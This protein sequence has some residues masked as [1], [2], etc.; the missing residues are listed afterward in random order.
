MWS[1]LQAHPEVRWLTW[2]DHAKE[3]DWRIQSSPELLQVFRDG[4]QGFR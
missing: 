1:T 4:V 3:T 2:F